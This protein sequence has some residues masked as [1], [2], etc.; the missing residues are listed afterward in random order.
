MHQCA[1]R[2]EDYVGLQSPDALGSCDSAAAGKMLGTALAA[3]AKALYIN[4]ICT[5]RLPA[6]VRTPL[7]PDNSALALSRLTTNPT[8]TPRITLLITAIM[9]AAVRKNCTQLGPG[10]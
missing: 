7:A 8:S 6:K 9:P 4:R 2:R 5:G 10:R 3:A 1:I